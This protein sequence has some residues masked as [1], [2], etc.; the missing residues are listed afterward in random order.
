MRPVADAGI[1]VWIRNSFTPENEGTKIT[2][3]GNPTA[4][5]VKAITSIS[6]VSLITVGGRGIVGVI[7]VAAK[8][9]TAAANVNA[10]VL[11]ISQASSENDIC[12]IVPTAD[13]E[14]TV[15]ALKQT[16]APN[17]AHHQVEHITVDHNICIVAVIGERM[18]GIPGLAGRIFN[19]VG[20]Q[21]ISVNVIAQG[22]SEY[23]VSFVINADAMKEALQALH[24]EFELHLRPD[25]V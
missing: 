18:H 4:S 9:F 19:A 15:K 11:M 2:P 16:F 5:G 21:N 10:N 24:D 14:K 6:G 17:L 13:A 25:N 8:T 22:S 1:P 20:K 12:F 7:G 3:T 23:N